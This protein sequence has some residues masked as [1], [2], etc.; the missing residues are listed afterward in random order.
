MCV[1]GLFLLGWVG[2]GFLDVVLDL[3]IVTESFRRKK[4]NIHVS[5][6]M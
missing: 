5:L 2:L 1:L 3:V 4:Q 6:P